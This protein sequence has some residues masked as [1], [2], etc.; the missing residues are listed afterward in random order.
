MSSAP[1]TALPQ[2]PNA[3]GD[4]PPRKRRKWYPRYKFDRRSRIGRRSDALFKSFTAQLGT[5]VPPEL[6]V[7]VVSA[8]ELTAL[9]EQYR[10]A[11]VRGEATVPLDDLVRLERLA[12]A[13][14]RSLHLDQRKAR[15]KQPSLSAYLAA[16][17]AQ[18]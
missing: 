1:L 9:A 5:E 4:Q 7:K 13:A 12:H 15:Q 18:P 16:R 6:A 10:A 11:F 3:S 14:V 17:G 8:C 2:Q